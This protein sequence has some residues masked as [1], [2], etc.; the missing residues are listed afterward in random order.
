MKTGL[1][2]A[3]DPRPPPAATRPPHRL[4]YGAGAGRGD[5]TGGWSGARVIRC[6]GWDMLGQR[7]GREAEIGN[8]RCQPRRRSGDKTDDGE[9]GEGLQSVTCEDRNYIN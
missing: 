4:L 2:P 8:R 6:G 7:A 1:I 3:V 9:D 5:V